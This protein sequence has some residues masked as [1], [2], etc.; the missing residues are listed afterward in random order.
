MKSNTLQEA[1]VLGWWGEGE[2]VSLIWT[3]SGS[4]ARETA[5]RGSRLRTALPQKAIMMAT[6]LYCCIYKLL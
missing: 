5:Q 6:I 2:I 1:R 3:C 4:G